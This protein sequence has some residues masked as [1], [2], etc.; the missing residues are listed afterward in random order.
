MCR[1]LHSITGS[2]QLWHKNSYFYCK[3]IR[4]ASYRS[5]WLLIIVMSA[6][7]KKHW[8]PPTEH[9]DKHIISQLIEPYSMMTLYPCWNESVCFRFCVASGTCTQIYLLESLLMHAI[10][11]Y[12][13]ESEWLLQTFVHLNVCFWSLF[14]LRNRDYRVM[15]AC[16]FF[17]KVLS[18]VPAAPR[19][20]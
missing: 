8:L 4:L 20:L 14:S 12:Q 7:K 17:F 16:F 11:L 6:W 3:Y 9:T 2:S 10:Y 19:G 13:P 18:K 15:V 5:P 1:W